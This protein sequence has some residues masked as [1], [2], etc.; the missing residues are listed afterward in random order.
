MIAM[1]NLGLLYR[2]G[3]GVD[4]DYAQARQWFQ[5]AAKAGDADAKQV[6]SRLP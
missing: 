1:Y 4:R 3:Q 2:N 5:K 6:L